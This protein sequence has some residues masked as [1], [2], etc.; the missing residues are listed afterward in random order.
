M[1]PVEVTGAKCVIDPH[2]QPDS[3]GVDVFPLFRGTARQALFE[4]VAHRKVL[5]PIHELGQ[6][7]L[8]VIAE[9]F[10][11]MAPNETEQVACRIRTA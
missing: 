9:S 4:A 3:I 6:F 1:E 11:I 5:C 10:N 7:S 2:C 8:F